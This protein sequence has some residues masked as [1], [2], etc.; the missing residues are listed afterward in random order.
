MRTDVPDLHGARVTVMGLGLFGAGVGVTKFLCR[1]GAHVTVTDLNDAERLRESVSELSG[2]PVEFQLGQHREEDFQSADLVVVS[3]AVP[4][5]SPW[6]DFAR[7]LDT[8]MNLFAKLCPA[9]TVYGITGSNGKTTT[10]TLVGE[11]LRRGPRRVWVGGNL[12]V[13]LLEVIDEISPDDI[14]VLELSSFQLQ[15]LDSI[16]W[17]PQ[18]SVVLNITPNHL[19]RH[20]SAE[21]YVEAKRAIVRH[22]GE[23][24]LR[25]LNADDP[26]VRTFAGAR[27]RWFGHDALREGTRV[28][29]E[30]LEH[31]G[32][33]LDVRGR[34]LPGVFNLH[35]MA[36]ATAAVA[37]AFPG[38][39]KAAEDVLVSF[40]GVEHRL[41]LVA[42]SGGVAY[43][44]D[45]IAT[46]P[47]RTLA[48][49]DTLSGP[50][51]LL[52][53][54]YDKGL[55]FAE[56]GAKV[57]E[58][59]RE[60]VLFGQTADALEEAIRPGGAGGADASVRR[61]TSFE[62]AVAMARTAA[63]PGDNV[64]LSPAC[65]SYGMF[66]NFTERGRRFKELVRAA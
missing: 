31:G 21:R 44:D 39:T 27:T 57:R 6:L 23:H 43:Y 34:R 40:A 52:L 20:G 60:V 65:A 29:P 9:R 18:V 41:E 38:W 61:A 25:I 16:G 63:R 66:R 37:E 56:L 55:S 46:T 28:L 42:E 15:H 62:E 33:V 45:S 36:A 51:V 5:D 12:G 11:I 54:G 7:E 49:L 24:D 19:D 10:T 13:S 2:W 8:E 1:A 58:R 4:E 14:V 30:R 59:C 48:A 26:T 35:N 53:G 47:E 3:P 22:Q 50:I 17:S 64:L 32:R